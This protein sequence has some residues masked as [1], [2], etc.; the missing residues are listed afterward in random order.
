MFILLCQKNQDSN[1]WCF[2]YSF[3]KDLEVLEEPLMHQATAVIDIVLAKRYDHV[4]ETISI[5]FD[6]VCIKD[7]DVVIEYKEPSLGG[8]MYVTTDLLGLS[9]SSGKDVWLCPVLTYFYPKL[10]KKLYVLITEET[11]THLD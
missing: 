3:S 11:E 4:P 5:I 10:P 2:D 9:E 6:H 1:L 7:A 8:S